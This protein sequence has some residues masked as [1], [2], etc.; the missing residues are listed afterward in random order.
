M[1]RRSLMSCLSRSTRGWH[2]TPQGGIATDD[3]FSITFLRLLTPTLA[4]GGDT[5]WTDRQRNGFSARQGLTS[6]HLLAK[7]L[8][9]E[10]DPHETLVSGSFIAGIGGLGSKGVGS[11]GPYSLGPSITFGKASETCPIN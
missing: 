11:G 1:T 4:V 2:P 8:L 7:S 3:N 5:T 6:T 10:N 9:Y